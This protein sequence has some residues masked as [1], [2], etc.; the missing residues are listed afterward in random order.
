MAKYYNILL[1]ISFLII[2]QFIIT[3]TQNVI[4]LSEYYNQCL[5]RCYTYTLV[6]P[7]D[8]DEPFCIQ[9]CDEMFLR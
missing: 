7:E 5:H 1:I 3:K 9:R 6:D 8:L 4:D 2:F